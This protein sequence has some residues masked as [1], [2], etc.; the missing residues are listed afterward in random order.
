MNDTPEF[1]CYICGA[2]LTTRYH[3]YGKDYCAKHAR[4]VPKPRMNGAF[5]ECVRGT[6]I[7]TI[8]TRY[9]FWRDGRKLCETD[10]EKDDEAIA[11]FKENHPEQFA[12]GAEM[13]ALL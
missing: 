6:I 11:W 12:Q 3:L 8:T 10:A 9:Q 2:F 4:D 5:D 1:T 13:R 7:G